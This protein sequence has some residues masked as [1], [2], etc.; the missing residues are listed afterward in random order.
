[1][2][3]NVR[4]TDEEHQALRVWAD[5]NGVSLNDALRRAAREMLERDQ[6]HA[7]VMAAARQ[8]ISRDRA[9]LERLSAT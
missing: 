9:L 8:V 5:A 4:L 2:A 1:M 6:H 3:L 7:K